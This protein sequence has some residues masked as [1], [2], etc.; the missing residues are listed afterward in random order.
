MRMSSPREGAAGRP[1]V[2]ATSAID[3]VQVGAVWEAAAAWAAERSARGAIARRRETQSRAWLWERVD[4]GLAE[5]FRGHPAVQSL[6]P[7]MLEGVDAGR[8][9][10]SVAARR[11]LRAFAGEP[12]ADNNP[13]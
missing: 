9:P 8:L 12:D 6:L 13:A 11:L 10:V 3:A 4:A 1:R 7:A 2:L 5:R